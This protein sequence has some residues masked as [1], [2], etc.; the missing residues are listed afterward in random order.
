MDIN[1]K[2]LSGLKLSRKFLILGVIASALVIVPFYQFFVLAQEGIES[3]NLEL[4]GFEPTQKLLNVIKLVQEHRGMSAAAL[5]G[6]E[7]IASQLTPKKQ[8][9]DRALADLESD[10]ANITDD[11]IRELWGT[12]RQQWSQVAS[13]VAAGTISGS[14]SFINHTEVVT[15]YLTQLD[16][17]LDHFG[18]SLDPRAESWFLIQ[19]AYVAIPHMNE[20]LGQLRGSGAGYLSRASQQRAQ[21]LFVD[22]ISLQERARMAALFEE[23]RTGLEGSI[24]RLD[25]A[26][27]A[28]SESLDS[29]RKPLADAEGSA[30]Q[31]LEMIQKEVV[32]SRS[33]TMEASEYFSSVT[34]AIVG[35]ERLTEAV[36]SELGKVL[37][38]TASDLRLKQLATSII[39]I[40]LIGFGL[41]A[42][43]LII[44]TI[45]GPVSHLQEVMGELRGGNT[46]IRANMSSTDE[47]GE[48]AQQF[49]R[50]V[51]EREAVAAQIKEE[52]EKLNDSVLALLQGVAQLAQRD[53]TA[54]VPVAED[55][56][57][58]VS[59]AL[60]M[61]S[62]ETARV[63]RQVSDISADVTGVSLK[64]K[65][66]SDAV[67]AAA[68][69]ERQQVEMTTEELRLAVKAMEQVQQL[70][71]SANIAADNAINTTQ[72]ALDTVTATVGGINDTRDTI[73][74]TEKRIKRLG[75]RSQEISGVVGL[76]NTIAERT[77]IL[78]LN[79]SMHAASAGEAGRGFAVVAE[80][81]QRLAENARQATA[82]IA[83]L[84][85]NIQV[86][87]VDTVNTMNMAISQVVDGSKLAEQAGEQMKLT[88][89][90]TSELVASV[91][92]ITISSQEQAQVSSGLLKRAG[93][94]RESTEETS[95]RL[96]EQAGYTASLVEYAKDLLGAIRV[97][98]LP[99]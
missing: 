99:V 19:A 36:V 53:L 60:N 5:A 64:V 29:L 46:T 40:A 96:N 67:M 91:R 90:T 13:A 54:K 85:N 70:A 25:K 21:G 20:A 52:N 16:L 75:E 9:V 30:R 23:A 35:Q 33:F 44:R 97:F 73:R 86:E 78:A 72:A 89:K 83:T 12:S 11:R 51:D 80:E 22:D 34:D 50:M 17:L 81:V 18:L 55:V 87:T 8:E 56:T 32:E 6:N 93:D 77:H 2:L 49:D 24:A 37:N 59:D 42:A 47:I 79:A 92:Q 7:E 69:S 68:A 84:V 62:T 61:L 94:I 82:Q 76:I 74:E 58:A 39:I 4:D 45:T 41:A 63:L 15:A 14:A 31:A 28:R 27:K 57:G 65:E 66:Q 1:S 3:A 43:V 71:Q 10:M 88:Q 95:H 38:N 26:M 48:L 98:K